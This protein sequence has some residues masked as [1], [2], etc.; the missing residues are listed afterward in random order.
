MFIY[1]NHRANECLR[2]SNKCCINHKVQTSGNLETTMLHQCKS[3]YI[4]D[5]N[6]TYVLRILH[7]KFWE[8][9][10]NTSPVFWCWWLTCSF[11]PVQNLKFCCKSSVVH[12]V[13]KNETEG[14]QKNLSYVRLQYTRIC[15][16]VNQDLLCSYIFQE[17]FVKRLYFIFLRLRAFGNF[18]K[19]LFMHSIYSLRK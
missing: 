7:C 5:D 12:L 3:A 9:Q 14:K 19:L 6:M 2:E 4:A 15:L 11:L 1:S 18:N 10:G 16:D 17:I 13:W 8:F